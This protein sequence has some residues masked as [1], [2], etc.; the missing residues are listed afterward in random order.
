MNNDCKIITIRFSC[1]RRGYHEYG[2]MWTP[3]LQEVIDAHL[4][5]VT[6]RTTGTGLPSGNVHQRLIPRV[7]GHL[8]DQISRFTVRV[9]STIQEITTD[10]WR[11]GDT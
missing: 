9:I 7:F 6:I 5:R 2:S 10:L 11:T 8:P 3:K 4:E 1:D